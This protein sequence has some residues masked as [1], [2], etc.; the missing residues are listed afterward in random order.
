VIAA[1]DGRYAM[2]PRG[3]SWLSTAGSGD[4]L[5]G[6]IGAR[7]AGNGDGFVAACEGVWLHSEAARRTL[8][9]FSAMDLAESLASAYRACL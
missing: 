6:C 8:A 5:A 2:A 3:S 4:V 1:P 9:P 7:L